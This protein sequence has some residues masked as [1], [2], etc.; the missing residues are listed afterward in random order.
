MFNVLR[1]AEVFNPKKGFLRNRHRFFTSISLKLD[2]KNEHSDY[3]ELNTMYTDMFD[4]DKFKKEPG[5]NDKSELEILNE[6][7]EELLTV[8]HSSLNSTELE[9]CVRNDG[10][11][12]IRSSSNNPY[13]NLALEDYIFKHTPL[14]ATRPNNRLLFYIND[15]C[16]VI[17]KNQNIWQELYVSEAERKGFEILRRFSGGGTVIHDLGNV[18]YS[19]ITSREKFSRSFFNE[20]IVKWLL[21][22]NQ[23]LSI[24]LNSRSD[25]YFDGKKCSGSAFKIAKGK[26]YHHGTMLINSKLDSFNGILRPKNEK[27]IIWETNSVDSMRAEITNLPLE[28]PERFIDICTNGFQKS[29]S[30]NEMNCLPLYY[31]S[32]DVTINEEIQKTMHTL[33]SDRFKYLH[34][35]KFKLKLPLTGDEFS[36]EN[37]VIV[38][39]S[40]PEYKNMPFQ[41]F[42]KC[43]NLM[44]PVYNGK[45]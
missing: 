9:N 27:D 36:V 13:Y 43:S 1:R 41:N 16:A 45:F 35:P 34:G 32:E 30:D 38:N 7:T 5:L 42:V 6:E 19:F 39:A 15:K 21:E 25:I 12:V 11:F 33:K 40:S 20:C 10:T 28:T 26:A 22:S 4:S 37:G 31:C 29:F 14:K 3:T 18:N 17:G 23:D 44:Q 2:N 24:S 8:K